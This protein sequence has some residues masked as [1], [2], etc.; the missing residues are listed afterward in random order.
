MLHISAAWLDKSMPKPVAGTSLNSSPCWLPCWLI[1]WCSRILEFSDRQSLEFRLLLKLGT[2]SYLWFVW[3]LNELANISP[4]LC[5]DFSSWL[6]FLRRVSSILSCI[7]L[8]FRKDSCCKFNCVFRPRT[9]ASIIVL[10][11]DILSLWSFNS[12]I[13]EF[14]TV[15][16]LFFSFIF[17]FVCWI[18]FFRS[19][20]CRFWC[21]ICSLCYFY[22]FSWFFF[23]I[24]YSLSTLWYY[25]VF[26]VKML[27]FWANLSFSTSI[28]ALYLE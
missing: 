3:S 1:C 17:I 25:L 2:S 16:W 23:F 28:I 4:P 9:L 14:F 18:C 10:L 26:S 19:I 15:V 20:S 24:L 21:K 22:I 8:L 6:R 7:I 13:T 5:P 11:L 12:A 27:Y